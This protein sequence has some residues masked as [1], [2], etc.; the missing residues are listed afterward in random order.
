M[1][2]ALLVPINPL[3]TFPSAIHHSS[4]VV[5]VPQ[6][7]FTGGWVKLKLLI[8]G[9]FNVAGNILQVHRVKTCSD[10]VGPAGFEPA[11]KGL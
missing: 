6:T 1:R 2:Q 4:V 5:D 9:Q 3:V 7:S 10:L 8:L 11:T